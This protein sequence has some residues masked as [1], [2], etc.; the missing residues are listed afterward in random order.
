MSPVLHNSQMAMENG[1]LPMADSYGRISQLAATLNVVAKTASYTC[2]PE[3]SGTFFIANHASVAVNF[4]LPTIAT[5]LKGVYYDFFN[6]GAAG[7]VIT[8]DPSDK[9]VVDNDA[10]ADTVTW[11]TASHIIGG[12][13]R[14]VCDGALWYVQKYNYTSTATDAS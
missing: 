6:V 12:S 5:G 1:S 10:A 4:T 7:M 2:L 9:L 14:V 13:A 3:E 11:S 8:S